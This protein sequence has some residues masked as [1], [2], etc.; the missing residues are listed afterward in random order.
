[1]FIDRYERSPTY[2]AAEKSSKMIFFSYL[3]CNSENALYEDKT[4][5]FVSFVLINK[6]F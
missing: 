3:C 5:H 1:M 2:R 6:E 4:K